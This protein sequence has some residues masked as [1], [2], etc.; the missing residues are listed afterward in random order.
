MKP[1]SF[2]G[3]YEKLEKLVQR[4]PDALQQPILREITPIKIASR[5]RMIT[6]GPPESPMQAEPRTYVVVCNAPWR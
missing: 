1:S 6:V 4:L 3:F 5:P 2:L